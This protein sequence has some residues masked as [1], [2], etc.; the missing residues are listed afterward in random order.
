LHGTARE[1]SMGWERGRY[2]TRSRKVNGRVVREYVGGGEFGT[3]VA[4]LDALDR[5]ERDLEREAA[6]AARDELARLDEPL[7]ELNELADRLVHA[8]LLVAGYRQHKR[9]EW[10]KKRGRE[11]QASRADGS[12]GPVG[13]S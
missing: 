6:R 2:Y 7:K 5:E 11:D 3:L 4:Q 9:G 8:A 1:K 10:R 12:V 13:V